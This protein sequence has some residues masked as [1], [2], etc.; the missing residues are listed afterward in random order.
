MRCIVLSALEAQT[1]DEKQR[2]RDRDRYQRRAQATQPVRE[3]EKH[4]L[5]QN[6]I[7]DPAAARP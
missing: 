2:G 5:A 3:K 1:E 6:C 7:I 4:G